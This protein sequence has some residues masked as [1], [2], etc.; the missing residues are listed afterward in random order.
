[1]K[2]LFNKFNHI[3]QEPMTRDINLDSPDSCLA[4]VKIIQKKSILKNVYHRW[5]NQ[6]EDEISG[7]QAI[8]GPVLELGS[9]AGFLQDFIPNLIRS[10]ILKISS[11]DIILDGQFLPFKSNSLKAIVL[12]DVFHHIPSVNLFLA[13]ALRCLKSGGVIV[14]VEPWCTPFSRL[15]YKYIH[16]EPYYPQSTNWAF[17]KAGPLSQANSALPWIVFERDRTIFEKKFKQLKI[18]KISLHTSFSY[19]FSGGISK[20]QLIPVT[21]YYLYNKLKKFFA[22]WSDY[23]ALFATI[24]VEKQ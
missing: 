21:I 3:I 24:I 13:E 20:K 10:E 14:M 8:S 5:Y 19:L 17:A 23:F 22:P 16:H 6:I 2:N 7:S 4:I 15:I 9:G 18:K 1:M 12:V 11:V